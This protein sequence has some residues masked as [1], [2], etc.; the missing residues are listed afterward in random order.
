MPIA[1][2]WG[3]GSVLFIRLDEGLCVPARGPGP[4]SLLEVRGTM[5]EGRYCSSEL[6]ARPYHIRNGR[7]C[8]CVCVCV[9]VSERER[10]RESERVRERERER[11][12]DDYFLCD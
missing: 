11:E 9:C 10:E 7:G 12:R 4:D 3:Q 2:L 5:L 8:V 6:R 1:P